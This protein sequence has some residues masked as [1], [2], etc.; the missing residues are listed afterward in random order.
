MQT[1]AQTD[2]LLGTLKIVFVQ[3]PPRYCAELLLCSLNIE[4]RGNN[5]AV[6]RSRQSTTA[7]GSWCP[8][9]E[10]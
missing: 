5:M 7:D 4:R 1:L 3:A 2:R 10:R 8:A 6:C 9:A